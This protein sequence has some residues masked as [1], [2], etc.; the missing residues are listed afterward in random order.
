MV[1]HEEQLSENL[2]LCLELQ[3]N[4]NGVTN[5]LLEPVDSTLHRV[6]HGQ[7]HLI[8]DSKVIRSKMGIVNLQN[9]VGIVH[10]FCKDLSPQLLDGS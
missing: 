4:D 2:D 8:L 3:P 5:D 1:L 6:A 10:R 7:L 9:D